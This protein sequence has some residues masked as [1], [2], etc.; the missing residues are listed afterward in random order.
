MQEDWLVTGFPAFRARALVQHVLVARP[1]V[2]L[3]LLVDRERRSAAE[4]V[5]AEL[6]PLLAVRV[7][8]SSLCEGRRHRLRARGSHLR[9]TRAPLHASAS[10]LPDARSEPRAARGRARERARRA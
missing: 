6:E 4:A 5:L 8:G 2:K 7:R 1:D 10:P 9:R 3:T